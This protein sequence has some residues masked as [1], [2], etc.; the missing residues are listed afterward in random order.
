MMSF[1]KRTSVKI[2]YI[3]IW[4]YNVSYD[5]KYRREISTQEEYLILLTHILT[6]TDTSWICRT[7]I[8][9]NLYRT[10]NDIVELLSSIKWTII[11]SLSNHFQPLS[12]ICRTIIKRLS[13]H[14]RPSIE[15]HQTSMERLSN[16]Y[17]TSIRY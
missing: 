15:S 3:I 5:I 7:L 17:R 1:M 2:L 9:L 6:L 8:F 14:S 13:D 16:H 4:E 11:T 10:T 12:N